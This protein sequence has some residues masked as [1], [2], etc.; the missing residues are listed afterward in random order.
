MRGDHAFNILLQTAQNGVSLRPCRYW[1]N[2][3]AQHDP[4]GGWNRRPAAGQGVQSRQRAGLG[5]DLKG[6][7]RLHPFFRRRDARPH[8]QS[9]N[10]A[11]AHVLQSGADFK[12]PSV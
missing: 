9:K 4:A 7:I 1:I 6:R 5:G 2:D 8:E 11:A 10:I 12:T 3:D